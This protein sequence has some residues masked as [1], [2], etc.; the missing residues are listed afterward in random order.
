MR[1]K[2]EELVSALRTAVAILDRPNWAASGLDKRATDIQ[3]MRRILDDEKDPDLLALEQ[4][5]ARE[6]E[7]LAQR[8]P[9]FVEPKR[10]IADCDGPKS[11]HRNQRA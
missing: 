10:D 7:L 4:S 11:I 1:A 8:C 9:P 2:R 3:R 5:Q 6:D